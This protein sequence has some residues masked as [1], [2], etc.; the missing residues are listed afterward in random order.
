M[1]PGSNVVDPSGERFFE[2]GSGG[3]G[4]RGDKTKRPLL[5]GDEVAKLSPIVVLGGWDPSQ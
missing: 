1:P 4:G 3:L 5:Y 2:Y